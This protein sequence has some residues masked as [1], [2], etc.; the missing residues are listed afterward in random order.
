MFPCLAANL[1]PVDDT[2][3]GD[4]VLVAKSL[5]ATGQLSEMLKVRV[6]HVVILV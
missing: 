6:I 5:V 1:D 4:P 3:T 2:V